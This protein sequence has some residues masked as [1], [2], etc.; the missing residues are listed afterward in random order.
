MGASVTSRVEAD[1]KTHFYLY[2]S[3]SG[4]GVGVLTAEHPLGPWSDPLGK[5]LIYQNMPGLENCPAPFDPG[6]CIDENGTGWLTFGG[7]N[8]ADG[9]VVHTNVP[10]VA[11]L[12]A[13]MLR[14]TASSFL[15]TPRISWSKRAELHRRHLLLHLLQ[16]L[17]E[18]QQ[19]GSQG[20]S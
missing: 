16:R 15:L 12:G 5:P 2:F 9:G 11:R 13:D 3:N 7:G 10:K 17:A 4:C 1:G 6:V 19:V 18:P 20:H 14:L 8:A